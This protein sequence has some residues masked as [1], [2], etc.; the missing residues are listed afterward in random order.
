M[1]TPKENANGYA[2]S[3]ALNAI[4]SQ[5]GR[6]LLISGTADD[7][8]H[9]ANTME[10]EARMTSQNKICD[11]M[12]Y[13]NMNHSINGCDVRYPLFMKVLDFYNVNLKN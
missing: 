4:S 5:K 2:N 7:N 13:T 6:V 8:V 12:I 9:I 10:Y 3:S 1:R 11:M